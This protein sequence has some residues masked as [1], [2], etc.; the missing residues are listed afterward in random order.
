M[1]G[2]KDYV[3]KRVADVEIQLDDVERTIGIKDVVHNPEAEKYLSL[4]EGQLEKMTAEEC[5]QAKYI[6]LQHAVVIQ[7]KI[8]RA[9]AVKN[10]C[11]R[12]V[13]V[14][15]AKTYGTIDPYMTYELK[16]EAT[17]LNDAYANRLREIAV[18]QQGIIDSLNYMGQAIN[19]VANSFQTLFTSKR[20][21]ESYHE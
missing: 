15:I 16:K 2:E 1:S 21:V 12:S 3:S 19:G 4:S 8:N 17:A 9:T 20:K 14:I 11:D 7:K 18:E 6:L 13:A 10:W 5:A